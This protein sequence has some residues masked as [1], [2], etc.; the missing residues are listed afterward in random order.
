MFDAI[1]KSMERSQQAGINNSPSTVIADK[2]S[3]GGKFQSAAKMALQDMVTS[4]LSHDKFMS[5]R[6]MDKNRTVREIQKDPLMSKEEKMVRIKAEHQFHESMEKTM[7]YNN[8]RFG[9]DILF[10]FIT[11]LNNLAKLQ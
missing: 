5:Q 8:T 3:V 4:G 2:A 7:A 11:S 10:K 9:M 1:G 6:H